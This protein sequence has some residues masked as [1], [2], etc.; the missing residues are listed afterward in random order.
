MTHASELLFGDSFTPK[1]KLQKLKRPRPPKHIQ[2]QAQPFPPRRPLPKKEPIKIQPTELPLEKLV[3]LDS[4]KP[5]LVDV[6]KSYLDDSPS[7]TLAVH[8]HLIEI[9]DF[10]LS[11]FFIK[12]LGLVDREF[13]VH[14]NNDFFKGYDYFAKQSDSSKHGPKKIFVIAANGSKRMRIK[15][16][17]QNPRPLTRKEK[18]NKK[19]QYLFDYPFYKDDYVCNLVNEVFCEGY[20]YMLNL[21]P[22]KL[23]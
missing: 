10:E 23:V 4:V 18:N 11:Y 2:K 12:C 22:E 15:K 16:L 17:G 9:G 1:P 8:D 6:V 20:N 3:K 14:C 19:F 7:E 21:Y 5:F 13:D